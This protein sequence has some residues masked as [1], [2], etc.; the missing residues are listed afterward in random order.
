MAIAIVSTVI[1]TDDKILMVQEGGKDNFG[2]WNIPSGGIEQGENIVE[3]SIRE[4][5]EETGYNVKVLGL[6]GVY[7]FISQ[8]GNHLVRFN[9]VS[10]IIDGDINFDGEDIINAKWFTFEEVLNMEDKKLWNGNSIKKII[11]DVKL[12]KR[13]PFELIKEVR[14]QL[15]RG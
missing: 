12:N 15:R 14:C 13:Y 2:L 4:V 7:N 8:I 10:E 9:F 6:T 1:T 11:E 3:A 5:K